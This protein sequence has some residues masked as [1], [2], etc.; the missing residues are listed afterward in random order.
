M[1]ILASVG[2]C[3]DKTDG[4]GLTPCPFIAFI[5]MVIVIS[6]AMGKSMDIDAPELPILFIDAEICV[7]PVNEFDGMAA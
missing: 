6:T 1:L 7:G 5:G 4:D 3:G 2:G